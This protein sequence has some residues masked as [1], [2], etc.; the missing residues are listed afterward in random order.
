MYCVGS[1]LCIGPAR[2]FTWLSFVTCNDVESSCKLDLMMLFVSSACC[3]CV[4]VCVCVI[5]EVVKAAKGLVGQLT[6]LSPLYCTTTKNH[7]SSHPLHLRKQV[8]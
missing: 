5:W 4:C 2:G 8:L 1:L 7:L 6:S 3:A